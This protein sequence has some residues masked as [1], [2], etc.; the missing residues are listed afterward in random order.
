MSAHVSLELEA[1]KVVHAPVTLIFLRVAHSCLHPTIM[2][3]Y[4]VPTTVLGA[5]NTKMNKTLFPDLEELLKMKK[6]MQAHH[7]DTIEVLQQGLEP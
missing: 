2:L 7:Y 5:Q 4:F 6:V 3:L 1:S